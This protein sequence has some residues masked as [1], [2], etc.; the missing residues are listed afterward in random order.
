MGARCQV[1]SWPA[2]AP[3]L[4]LAW[5]ADAAHMPP[6]AT[7]TPPPFFLGAGTR[8]GGGTP[9]VI[10]AAAAARERA[11]APSSLR[12]YRSRGAAAWPL[13]SGD[14]S[15]WHECPV[16]LTG[17]L[18]KQTLVIGPHGRQR[19]RAH[20]GRVRA[21]A[22]PPRSAPSHLLTGPRLRRGGPSP[23][24]RSSLNAPCHKPGASF[25]QPTPEPSVSRLPTVIPSSLLPSSQTAPPTPHRPPPPP[26]T[27]S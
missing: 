26:P 14:S 15:C 11:S 10:S 21:R 17:P 19:D 7:W 18:P 25:A 27:T 13:T 2:L 8:D 12:S 16:V 4:T 23:P 24:P 9:P 6:L 22:R 1:R 3:R 5:C 20:A